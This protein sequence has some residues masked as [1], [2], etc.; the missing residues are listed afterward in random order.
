MRTPTY[1]ST[2]RIGGVPPR[3]YRTE[4]V[5]DSGWSE[6]HL[7]PNGWVPG[8]QR[9]L[10][11]MDGSEIPRPPDAL[12]T[13]RHEMRQQSGFSPEEYSWRRMWRDVSVPEPQ[14]E[15]L[16]SQFGWPE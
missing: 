6:F 10:D 13:W 3:V 1:E 9:L 14:C 2:A 15:K 16:R 11:R 4:M 5:W 7:T 12:E 8:A